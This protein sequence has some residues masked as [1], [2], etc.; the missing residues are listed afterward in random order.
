MK[1]E[2][3]TLKEENYKLKLQKIEDLAVERDRYGEYLSKLHGLEGDLEEARTHINSLNDEIKHLEERLNDAYS[4][5]DKLY[6]IMKK[7]IK[8]L[9][10]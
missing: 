2:L 7:A 4:E 5:N 10:Q 3:E 9:E 8:V 6:A 1:S